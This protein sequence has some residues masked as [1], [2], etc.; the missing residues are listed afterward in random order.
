MKKKDLFTFESENMPSLCSL[1]DCYGTTRWLALFELAT[2]G[3]VE[4][5]SG[6]QTVLLL[7]L[8][9]TNILIEEFC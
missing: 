1:Q 2:V 5:D 6:H 7:L 8:L 4:A 9:K 3:D